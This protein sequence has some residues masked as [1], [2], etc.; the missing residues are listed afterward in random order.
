MIPH[1]FNPL[2]A[3][4]S[5]ENGTEQF[6]FLI[7]NESD[8]VAFR[9]ALINGNT[10]TN[11]HH[12]LMADLDLSGISFTGANAQYYGVFDGNFKVIRNFSLTTSTNNTGLFQWLGGSVRRLGIEN[13]YIDTRTNPVNYYTGGLCGAS[14]GGVIEQCYVTGTILTG[15]GRTGGITGAGNAIIRNCWTNVAI[16]GTAGGAIGGI[17][18][19]RGGCDKCLAI[20][21]LTLS[22]GSNI[23]GISGAYNSSS[24]PGVVANCVAAMNSVKSYR[25]NGDGTVGSNNYALNTMLVNGATV[26]GTDTSAN[27][28]NAT[29]QQLKSLAFYRDTMGWD[30]DNIWEIDDGNDFPKL[31]GF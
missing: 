20:G 12:K 31:R 24:W 7:Q 8:F 25:I 18:G 1:P 10:W 29:I 27:G 9:K 17:I 19:N 14:V 22:S 6:P 30:M 4:L 5:I 16:S 28:A 15:N 2:G 23:G 26:T 13:I 11:V 21:N 3:S